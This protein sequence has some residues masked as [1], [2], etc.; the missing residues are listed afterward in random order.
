MSKISTYSTSEPSL[1]DMIIGTDAN[2]ENATKNFLIADILDLVEPM[3]IPS[4]EYTPTVQILAGITSINSA[5]VYY[6][7]FGSY[8]GFA[9]RFTF[10][11]TAST[12]CGFKFNLPINSSFTSDF[13]AIGTTS[14]FRLTGSLNAFVGESNIIISMIVLNPSSSYD[15]SISGFYKIR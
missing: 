15:I 6:A 4:G 2:D 8:V 14:G 3:S 11:N 1:S 5:K 12:S 9:G 13:D 10:A 7:K